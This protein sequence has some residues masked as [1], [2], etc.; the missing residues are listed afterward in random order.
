M[1]SFEGEKREFPIG[2]INRITGMP[3]PIERRIGD[4]PLHVVV[5]PVA[6]VALY[7]SELQIPPAV[8]F[9]QTPAGE[10]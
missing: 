9:E 1:Y 10:L 5:R 2:G 3:D 6:R 7:S 4:A 8:T